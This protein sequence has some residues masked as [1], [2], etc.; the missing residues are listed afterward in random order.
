MSQLKK[1]AEKIKKDL[2]HWR[3]AL[4]ERPE[5]GF[6][7]YETSAFIRAKLAEMGL[8]CQTIAKTGVVAL[9]Q[10]EKDGPTIGLRADID[11]LPIQDEKQVPYASKSQGKGHLCG[12]DAHTAML[13]G[14]AKLLAANKPKKGNVKLIF[15][16]AEEGRFGAEALIKHGVLEDPKVSVIAALHVNPV[17]PAGH[18]TCS[19]KEVCAA[20]DFFDIDIIGEGGHA[21][22][23]H[24]SVDSIAMSAEVISSLQQIVSRQIDPL[25]PTVLTIGQIHGGSANSVI[26]PSVKIGGTVRTFDPD[27]RHSMEGRI[28]KILR[29]ITEGLGGSYKLVYRHIYPPLM[30]DEHLIPSLMNTVE[31]VLGKNRFSFSKPSMGGED[32]SFYTQ[33]IPGIYFRLGVRN[34]SKKAI[35]PLHHPRFD[36]DEDALPYGAALLAQYALDLLQ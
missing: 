32:F 12:H 6:E 27:I 9:I 18:V 3:R 36:L 13:L 31:K 25:S 22:H 19:Q 17:I 14:A 2:V 5:L 33:K 28:D 21:A 34:E 23:P 24:L 10:G 35:Y 11:A 1:E 8:S 4:H 16:P 26:A 29:G 30:N 7:E 20:V 15:Q